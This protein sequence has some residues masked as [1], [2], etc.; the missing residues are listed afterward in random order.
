MPINTIRNNTGKQPLE[1]WD[2]DRQVASLAQGKAVHNAPVTISSVTLS[3]VSYH[4]RQGSFNN[5][6]SYSATFV[7]GSNSVKFAGNTGDVTF[8]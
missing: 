6:D 7:A 4:N 8:S 3:G 5:G 1:L 2:A